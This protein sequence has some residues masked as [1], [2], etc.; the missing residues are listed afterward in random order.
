M[1]GLGA[2]LL[3][4][5]LAA[6]GGH[7][8]PRAG[9]GAGHQA[10]FVSYREKAIGTVPGPV[11]VRRAWYH[12]R[13]CGRG[14]AP[15]DSDLGVAGVSTSPGLRKMTARVAAVA[16]FARAGDLLADLAGLH[17]TARRIERSAEADGTAAAAATRAAA[18]AILARKLI[19]MPPAPLPGKLYIAVDGTGVPMVP[20][21]TAGRP[22]KGP[23]GRAK[24]R[25]V[26]LACL[27][28]QTTLDAGGRPVRDPGSSTYLATFAPAAQF[29]RLVDAEARRRGSQH[30]RQLV[31]LGD[32][33]AWI[34]N[35]AG[36][37]LPAATQIVDLYHAREHLHELAGL[38]AFMLGG[39]HN[40]WLAA[41]LTELDNGDIPAITAAAREFPLAGL[42]AREL[43]KALGYFETSAHRMQYARFRSLGMLVGSGMVEAGCKAV[44]GQR[45]KL[46]GMHWP[47]RGA[48][49]IAALRC[50]DASGRW[51]EIW[52][53]PDTQIT[54][55]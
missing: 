47:A 51:D 29:A 22:G 7:R 12:R 8:G 20:A 9:C 28:T 36:Q 46:S 43:D 27:F 30:V 4:Q 14:L 45:M 13:E 42:K 24:T 1:T 53:H 52:Q 33:A 26:K 5:L 25:E 50:Q 3:E 6:G 23:D 44:I 39:Q 17:L 2:S 21:E 15:A 38:V 54:V 35:L 48:A 18:D 55:A 34:W 49:G 31:V 40:D 32:G 19:P 16:P 10:E 11:S 41:R 37:I